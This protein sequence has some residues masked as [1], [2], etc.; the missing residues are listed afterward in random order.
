VDADFVRH[1]FHRGIR[2]CFP[3]SPVG[4]CRRRGGGG[5]PV[6]SFG[7]LRFVP[8]I[9]YA[10]C[11]WLF[12]AVAVWLQTQAGLSALSGDLAAPDPPAHFTTGVM[13]YD[14]LRFHDS[15]KPLPFAECFYVQ[16][17]KVA[18]GHWP[19][20]FYVLEALCFLIFGARI[21]VARCLCAGIAAGTA[22]ALYRR[23]RARWGV[24]HAVVAA[25][26]FLSLPVVRS[27]AWDVMSD[28]L[29]AGFIFL[30]VCSL[31]DF[32][33]SGTLRDGF[34]LAAWTSLAI[35]TKGTGWLLVG[36]IVAGPLL[37]GRKSIYASWRYW[38]VLVL[39]C[40]V[41]APFFVLMRVLGLSYVLK[42]SEHVRRIT[43]ILDGLSSGQW[44]AAGLALACLAAT[45]YRWLP[46]RPLAPAWNESVLLALWGLT[47]FAFIHLVPL[48][49]ELDRYY[50]PS[51]APAAYLLAGLMFSLERRTDSKLSRSVKLV[52][53]LGSAAGC[54]L[55]PVTFHSTST[56][57]DAMKAIPVS[58]GRT[59]ILL[60]G[61]PATEGAMIAAR[62]THD[63][64]RST[65]FLRGTKFLASS[66]WSG[67][68]AVMTYPSPAALR[69]AL[70]DI[71]LHY[72]VLDR[73]APPTP[74]L[75]QVEEVLSAPGPNWDVIAQYPVR[76]NSRSGELLVFRRV[77]KLTHQNVPEMLR[78]GP[79][80]G[81]RPVVC[82]PWVRAGMR[83]S[84]V[85]P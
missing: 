85:R 50:I 72:I 78:L 77:S 62:L 11:P 67:A 84:G 75:S 54:A 69:A 29:L 22:L 51:I 15:L 12:L 57:S 76:L 80:R 38:L 46:R 16:Y 23:C 52:F 61:D 47:Q 8:L 49:H 13:V 9:P 4:S 26:L 5:G 81:S 34:R 42:M 79:E 70:D 19:P 53:I 74:A 21:E 83:R 30:A 41:S 18:L 24:W 45:L 48:T 40:A 31:A 82:A 28:L 1:R 58:P 64:D 6:S 44:F 33:G 25:A 43:L 65:F 39:T 36:P 37:V 68:H 14:F 17:P 55:V 10:W 32:L 27:Q 7:Y 71:Q 56:F 60:A 2:S 63:A 20:V 35:L 3:P 59:V 73:S 66:E